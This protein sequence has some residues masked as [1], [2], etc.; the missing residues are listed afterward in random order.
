MSQKFSLCIYSDVYVALSYDLFSQLCYVILLHGTS[1]QGHVIS[2]ASQRSKRVVLPVMSEELYAFTEVF[3]A[4]FILTLE[5]WKA[6]GRIMSISI[7]TEL[8]Q[9]FNV[10]GRE[11]RPLGKG[12]TINVI[13]ARKGCHWFV[14]DR[15]CLVRRDDNPADSLRKVNFART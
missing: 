2:Y 6:V 5:L 13:G 10:V 12:L 15:V 14:V 9:I 3:D 11:K 8:K 1:N 4:P 7:Y